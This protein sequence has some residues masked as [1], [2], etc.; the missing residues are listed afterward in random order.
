MFSCGGGVV[1]RSSGLQERGRYGRRVVQLG[2]GSRRRAGGGHDNPVGSWSIDGPSA[3][4]LTSKTRSSEEA[5]E[6]RTRQTHC[7][8]PCDNPGVTACCLQKS[9][10]GF[11]CV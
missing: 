4:A 1:I 3:E 9:P 11:V 10:L 6:Q 5:L 2:V 8:R 7:G